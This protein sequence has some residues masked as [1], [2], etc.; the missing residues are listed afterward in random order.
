LPTASDQHQLRNAGALANAGA[1]R[2]VL[3]ADMSGARLVEEVRRLAGE[4]GAMEAMARAAGTF[5]KAGA[6]ARAAEILEGFG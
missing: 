1:A 4:S 2:L 3:D 5:A 6:A